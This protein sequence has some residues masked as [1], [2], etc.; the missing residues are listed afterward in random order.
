MTH[1]GTTVKLR[2]HVGSWDSLQLVKAYNCLS[3]LITIHTYLICEYFRNSVGA[4]SF[5]DARFGRG[6]GFIHLDR[7]GC[8]GSEQNLLN[9]SHRSIGVTSYYCGHDDDAGIRCFGEFNN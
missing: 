5:R 3:C 1:I 9:C 2:W 6:T 8:S 4:Q 7:L